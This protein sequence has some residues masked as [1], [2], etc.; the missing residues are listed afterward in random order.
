[1]ERNL[2]RSQKLKLAMDCLGES[3]KVN[4]ADQIGQL[5]A[6]RFKTQMISKNLSMGK[7]EGILEIWIPVMG[8]EIRQASTYNEYGDSAMEVGI[9]EIGNHGTFLRI[10]YA[11]I[12]DGESLFGWRFVYAVGVNRF[13][14][15]TRKRT[16]TL[17]KISN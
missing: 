11:D 6:L 10:P 12:P 9:A 13:R 8:K 1:M 2:E 5:G 7:R 16:R 15:V 3:K 14:P 4:S 17:V